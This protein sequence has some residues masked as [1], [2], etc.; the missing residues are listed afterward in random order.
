VTALLVVALATI[1]AVEMM[2]RQQLDIRRTE[3]MINGDQ[4]YQYALGGE[5]WAVL[6]LLR[7]R[8]HSS[9]DH[10]NE[11]WATELPPLPIEG[12]YLQAHLEDL[13]SRFNLNNLLTKEGKVNPKEVAY[14]ERLLNLLE[15]PPTLIPAIIDWID[16]DHDPQIADGAEDDVYLA[17]N[18]AYRT[19][20]TL[21]N[22]PSELR[23]VSGF[24]PESYN[25]LAPY[26]TTLPSPTLININTAPALILRALAPEIKESDIASLIAEREQ[27]FFKTKPEFLEHPAF[28]GLKLND[29]LISVA[30]DFFLL[31]IKT[32]VGRGQAQLT[33]VLHRLSDKVNVISRNQGLQL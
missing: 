4:A 15:L 28:A 5:N 33:S 31:T 6:I 2:T 26:I 30:S 19:A 1:V 14:F 3:N 22:N 21:L 24:D 18:P 16:S 17:K 29:E 9:I 23:S 27:Q 8:Q 7:D 13:Q 20:N 32:Q 11:I 10:L 12:G 25:K